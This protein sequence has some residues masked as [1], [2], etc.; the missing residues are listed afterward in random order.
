MKKKLF[1]TLWARFSVMVFLIHILTALCIGCAALLLFNSGYLRSLTRNPVQPTVALLATSVIIGTSIFMFVSRKILKPIAEFNEAAKDVAR[2]NFDVVM[3]S[4]SGVAE[5]Q[6]MSNSFNLMVRELGSIETLRS[7]FVVSVSHEF[8]TPLAAIEGYATLL[9]DS[10]LTEAERDEYVQ[11][12]MGS[13]RQLSTLT[14]NVLMLSRLENQEVVIDKQ[15]FRLDEQIRE[16][17]LWLESKWSEKEIFLE[18]ELDKIDYYGNKDLIMQIWINLLDNAIKFVPYRGQVS[19]RLFEHDGNAIVEI[20]DNGK[21]IS[22]LEQRHIFEKFYQ[23]DRARGE[24]GNG[25]GLAL[26][27]RILDLCGGKIKVES[28]LGAE[29]VFT[30]FLQFDKEYP[31]NVVN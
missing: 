12:I 9:Q 5:I 21:G 1:S 22:P 2:G 8:K 30:V 20:R 7:D 18:V 17:V 11:I 29:T 19:T 15:K 10:E 13:S 23:G 26:V 28:R 6:E 27:Q 16:A 24:V 14:K 3:K 25:L 31:Q 4:K